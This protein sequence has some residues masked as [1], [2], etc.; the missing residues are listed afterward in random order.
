MGCDW[1]VDSRCPDEGCIASGEALEVC[2]EDEDQG[3][4][5]T[6]FWFYFVPSQIYCL[7]NVSFCLHINLGGRRHYF[8]WF[9]TWETSLDSADREWQDYSLSDYPCL[10]GCCSHLSHS[11][12]SLGHFVFSRHVC[13]C[14]S[15]SQLGHSGREWNLFLWSLWSGSG[16]QL[17]CARSSSSQLVGHLSQTPKLASRCQ[18]RG[19]RCG[20]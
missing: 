20:E 1:D 11:K 14:Q 2:S 4:D 3:N 15:C 6:S 19:I 18:G 17:Y 7:N 16:S 8:L 13:R 10:S 5:S 9:I 12:A